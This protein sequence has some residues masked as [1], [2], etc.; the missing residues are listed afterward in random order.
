MKRLK[1]NA[2]T[3]QELAEGKQRR[4]T[5]CCVVEADLVNKR[6]NQEGHNHLS[7]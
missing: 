6:G 3:G 4:E 7:H 2:Q 1:V 5:D